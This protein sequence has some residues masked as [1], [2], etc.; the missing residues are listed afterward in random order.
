MCESLTS[1]G[2]L[3]PSYKL[4]APIVGDGPGLAGGPGCSGG[5]GGPSSPDPPAV[6]ALVEQRWSVGLSSP[7]R[8]VCPSGAGLGVRYWPARTLVTTGREERAVFCKELAQG[9]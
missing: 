5:P 7:R 1:N 9:G 4:L 6:T 3:R 2:R 8:G